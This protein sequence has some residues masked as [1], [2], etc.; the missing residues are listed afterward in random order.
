M[1]SD[2]LP[3]LPGGVRHAKPANLAR[4]AKIAQQSFEETEQV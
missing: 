3:S 4:L 1:S 2:T